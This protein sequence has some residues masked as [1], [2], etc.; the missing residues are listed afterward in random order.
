ME[1]AQKLITVE[2]NTQIGRIMM[3]KAVIQVN[4]KVV[5]TDRRKVLVKK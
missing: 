3:P 5:N 2:L 4:G 1:E